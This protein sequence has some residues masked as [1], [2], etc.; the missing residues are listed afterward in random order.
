[1][2]GSV[3]ERWATNEWVPGLIQISAWVSDPSPQSYIGFLSISQFLVQKWCNFPV[4]LWYIFD[5][6][7]FHQSQPEGIMCFEAVS[8]SRRSWWAT[9]MQ[10]SWISQQNCWAV[11]KAKRWTSSAINWDLSFSES[12]FFEEEMCAPPPGHVTAF[13]LFLHQCASSYAM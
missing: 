6:R 9:H 13:T 3:M 10:Y 7:I 1:M 8:V 12:S 2:V 11:Q 4:C 5:F